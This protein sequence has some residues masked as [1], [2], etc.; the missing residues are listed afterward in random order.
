M[1]RRAIRR[2]ADIDDQPVD[3]R[4]SLM[5]RSWDDDYRMNVGPALRR[6]R[7]FV[8]PAERDRLK[9]RAHLRRLRKQGTRRTRARAA[10]QGRDGF[11]VRLAA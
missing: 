9:H 10:A 5:L 6:R 2:R 4:L 1:S 11:T 3:R 8:G 7:A